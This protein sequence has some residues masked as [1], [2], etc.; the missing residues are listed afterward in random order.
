M[1]W[2]IR[3]D[4]RLMR[5]VVGGVSGERV[6]WEGG[7]KN[8][9]VGVMGRAEWWAEAAEPRMEVVKDGWGTWW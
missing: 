3:P 7:G 9:L 8:A 5:L 6:R 1:I 2:L 4:G